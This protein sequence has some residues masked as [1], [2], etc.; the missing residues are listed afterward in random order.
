MSYANKYNELIPIYKIL[1]FKLIL[2]ANNA[3]TFE[4]IKNSVKVNFHLPFKLYLF[5]K[6]IAKF[7]RQCNKRKIR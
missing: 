6:I 2:F 1:F 3:I 4:T 7:M 5:T